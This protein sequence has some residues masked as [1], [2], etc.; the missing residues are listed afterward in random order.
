M[1]QA[2]Q[3]HVQ[4]SVQLVNIVQQEVQVVQTVKPDIIVQKEQ[5]VVQRAVLESGAQKEVQHVIK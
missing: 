2:H 1:E 5:E 3:Q 4:I